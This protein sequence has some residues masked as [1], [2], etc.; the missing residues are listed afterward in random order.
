ML[1]R[2]RGSEKERP[3]FKTFPRHLFFFFVIL[4]SLMFDIKDVEIVFPDVVYSV[5]I[6]L[7]CK[8]TAFGASQTQK[9]PLW[10]SDVERHTRK[11]NGEEKKMYIAATKPNV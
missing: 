10:I 3:S 5:I 6:N 1:P 4:V 9:A 11:E 7:P 8:T 2:E